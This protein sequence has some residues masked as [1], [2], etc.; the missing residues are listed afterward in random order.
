MFR[1]HR[2]DLFETHAHTHPHDLPASA[3]AIAPEMRGRVAPLDDNEIV[4]G[5]PVLTGHLGSARFI[6]VWWLI[7][8][9]FLG[10]II[11]PIIVGS[12]GGSPGA[13]L[14]YPVLFCIALVFKQTV[15]PYTFTF[16]DLT[17]SPGLS[18]A[19]RVSESS[20]W[21]HSLLL[22]LSYCCYC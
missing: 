12:S 8:I 5:A 10:N 3:T 13:T 6:L 15:F 17:P 18:K 22:L 1:V 14:T 21:S 7:Y 9:T 19:C 16:L 4:A 11:V 2:R 20:D